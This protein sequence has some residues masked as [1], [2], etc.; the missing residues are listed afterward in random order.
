MSV[1]G[2]KRVIKILLMST[3]LENSGHKSGSN[4]SDHYDRFV[5]IVNITHTNKSSKSD[6]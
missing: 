1:R 4:Y 3:T 2:R 5:A 6:K